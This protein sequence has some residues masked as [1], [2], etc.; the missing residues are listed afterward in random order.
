VI[1]LRAALKGKVTFITLS[2][3]RCASLRGG[4]CSKH[5]AKGPA[6]K[7]GKRLPTLGQLTQ[8]PTPLWQEAV[9]SEWYGQHQ[10]T[11]LLAT[12]TAWRY[13][14]GKPALPIDWELFRDAEGKLDTTALHR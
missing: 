8:S 2:S 11:M 5:R 13:H 10:Q 9:F 4:S 6:A 12:G 14:S 3:F 7:K 1:D